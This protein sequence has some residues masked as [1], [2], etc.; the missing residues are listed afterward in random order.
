MLTLSR[1]YGKLVIIIVKYF[2]ISLTILTH[3]LWE[4][5]GFKRKEGIWI[6]LGE[7][8]LRA[9]AVNS[10]PALLHIY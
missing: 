3:P 9:K 7:T 8:A 5:K 2:G 4:I 1:D 6:C 10:S